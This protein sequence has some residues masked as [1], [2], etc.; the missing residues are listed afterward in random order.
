MPSKKYDANNLIASICQQSF[1]F[2]VKE[3]WDTVPGAGKLIWNWHLSVICY[4]MQ[5]HAERVFKNLP[6]LE[7]LIFNV[8]PGTS[9]PVC[10]KS[11][12]LMGDG[13]Y[14]Q[15]REVQIGEFVIGKSGKPCKVLAVHEQGELSTVSIRTKNGRR[16]LAAK[17]HPILTANGWIVAGDIVPGQRLAVMQSSCPVVDFTSRGDDEFTVA[18]Y[19][20]G[21]GCLAS[22]NCSFTNS[23]PDYLQDFIRGLNGCGF[24]HKV[25]RACYNQKTGITTYTIHLKNGKGAKKGWRKGLPKGAKGNPTPGGPREWIRD[26]ELEGKSSKT[27]RIPTFV[28]QGTNSQVAKFLAA[29]FH[30]DGTVYRSEKGKVISISMTTISPGLARDLQRLFLRLGIP[31]RRVRRINKKGFVYNRTLVGYRQWSLESCDL[32]VVSRFASDI[33]LIG[34]KRAKLGYPP[35]TRFEGKYA[36]DE[37][38]EVKYGGK[39]FCRCLTVDKDASFTVGD[40]VVHNSTLCSILFQPWTWTV[41]PHARHLTGSHTDNLALDLA[42]KSREVIKSEKYRSCFKWVELSDVQDTKGYYRNT[43]GGDRLT[44]TVGG[45]SPMGFHAHF[46]NIDDP[47]DPKKARSEAETKTAE[48]FMLHVLPSRKVDKRVTLMTLIMQ[49]LTGLDPTQTLLDRAKRPGGTPIR[50]ICLPA[51]LP[52][53]DKNNVAPIELREKYVDG[54]LDPVRLPREV[55]VERKADSQ[56]SYNGQYMQNP[57]ALGGG[58]FK[59]YYFSR[60]VPAA[61]LR[62]KRIRYWDRASTKEGD[63]GC[64]TAGVLM[65]KD[66][67]G[68]IYVEHVRTGEWEPDERNNTM[69]AMAQRDR[70]KYGPNH[71]PVIYTEREGGSSGK[72]AHLGVVR[73]LAGFNVQ[74]QNVSGMGSKEVRA[75]PWSSHLAAGNVVLVSDGSWDINN[76]I[77]E[78]T[79]FPLGRLKDQVD[80]ASGA[81]SL[82]VARAPTTTGFRVV[83]IG[84]R[85]RQEGF[86]IV[87][88]SLNEIEKDDIPEKSVFIV[89]RYLDEE[90]PPW[91]LQEPIDDPL[92]LQFTDIE[93]EKYQDRWDVPVKEWGDKLPAEL[94]MGQEH[95]KKLWRYLRKKNREQP[96]VIVIADDFDGRVALSIAYAIADTYDQGRKLV[97][98]HGHEE[99]IGPEEV[100]NRHVFEMTK[101]M[102]MSVI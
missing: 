81:F 80:A 32:D 52:P 10:E 33:P 21:D 72:D 69:L 24:D 95:G 3:F 26:V 101:K 40:V 91:R 4:E 56:Y 29:Y 9:K 70:E 84:K 17:D 54:L 57:T 11:M 34:P 47:I 60:R 39:R 97:W 90:L 49:R 20:V 25:R 92:L 36:S 38:I 41:M 1:E 2:F 50:H 78:H 77:K 6:R 71:E 68:L 94:M 66:D 15:L 13:R 58:M 55:L 18:G 19:M 63:G 12:V 42:G 86:R 8:P 22:G 30:C 46:Q 23:D 64:R 79:D 59:D 35:R 99:G 89:V 100:P 65:C 44:C 16:V 83:P 88:G 85:K 51:E 62:S 76:F 75:E 102:R 31:L 28:W 53:L 7:D 37:V 61:P 73:K 96:D 48:D 74:E 14:K 67:D 93:P 43:L 98:A 82:L 5:V 45:K 27:K 87:A